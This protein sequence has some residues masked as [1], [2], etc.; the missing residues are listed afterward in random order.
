MSDK[1]VVRF[2]LGILALLAAF[3]ITTID[4]KSN[5]DDTVT[6]LIPA[7]EHSAVANDFIATIRNIASRYGI[8]HITVISAALPKDVYAG[9]TGDTIQISSYYTQNPIQWIRD[10]Q[11]DVW[12]GYHPS[13]CTAGGLLA[14]HETAH[15]LQ[16]YHPYANTA[17]QQKYGTGKG[18][19]L[20]GYSFRSDGTLNPDE[21][22]AEAFTAV[23]CGSS[24]PTQQDLYRIL[25]SS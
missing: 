5:A 1:R 19:P 18:L 12:Q 4:P 2:I 14:A 11:S 21:A 25:V 10:E 23:Y 6:D 8:R 17:L 16:M 22:L 9:T 3:A 20:S 15:V 7:T 13:G 24:N